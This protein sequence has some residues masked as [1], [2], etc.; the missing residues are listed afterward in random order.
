MKNYVKHWVLS[1]LCEGVKALHK[2]SRLLYNV[3]I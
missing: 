1:D 3:E 2:E